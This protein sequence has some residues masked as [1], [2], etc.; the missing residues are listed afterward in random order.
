[1]TSSQVTRRIALTIGLLLLAWIVG[2]CSG[3]SGSGS[4]TVAASAPSG[5]SGAG[6]DSGAP[7]DGAAAEV[8][9]VAIIGDS[10]TSGSAIGGNGAANWTSVARDLLAADGYPLDL[11]VLGLSG[12][13]YVRVGGTG[14]TF[15]GGVPTVVTERTQL[16]V[17][18]GSI[19]DGSSAPAAVAASAAEAMQRIDRAA[20][21]AQIL[22]IGPQWIDGDP[23]ASLL[24]IRDAVASTVATHPR[25]VFVDPL[26]EGWFGHESASLIGSDGLHPT[27][28]GHRH[29]AE[30]IAPRMSAAIDAIRHGP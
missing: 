1:M 19:N 15:T 23:P 30:L 18:F 14:L 8:V 7:A 11:A 20:P 22:I 10:Y 28:A 27:D 21:D 2:G 12:S 29:L 4:A 16:V 6:P 26:A 13:G 3:G 9:H 24:A 5:A 17:V 25:L